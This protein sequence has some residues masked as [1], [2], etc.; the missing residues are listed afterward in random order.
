MYFNSAY[1]HNNMLPIHDNSKPL[2]VTSAGFYRFKNMKIFETNRPNGRPD[3]QF[4]YISAGKIHFTFQG[5]NLILSQGTAILFRPNQP[6]IYFYKKE[7][8]TEVYWIHFTGS[9]VEEIL[10]G[11]QFDKEKNVYTLSSSSELRRLF[12]SVIYE[13]HLCPPFYM[14]TCTVLLQEILLTSQRIIQENSQNPEAWQSV[15]I[16]KQSMKYFIE[17]YNS[18]INISAYAKSLNMSACWFIRKFKEFLNIT[19][20]QYIISL[21]MTNAKLLLETQVLNIS[22]VAYQVGYDNPLY[23]SRLFTKFVGV[24]PKEYKK[25]QT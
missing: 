11:Y 20:M 13:L 3:Y 7:E 5:E 18:P 23:F 19:P 4:L 10:D 9:K 21:R 16:I 6:Q 25:A 1:L 14:E 15:D 8:K 22:Q 17:N 2:I 24:S 12:D